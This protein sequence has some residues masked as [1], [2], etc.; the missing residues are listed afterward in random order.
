MDVDLGMFGQGAF[1]MI[2]D[3]FHHGKLVTALLQNEE[4]QDLIAKRLAEL[5]E[6]PLSDESMRTRIDEISNTIRDE[7]PMEAAR[8]GYNTAIWERFVEEIYDHC[9]GRAEYMI[10]N[11]CAQVGFTAAEKQKYFGHLLK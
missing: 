9:D 2:A 11:F 10:N 1:D 3:S 7:I 8:W 4:F 5:L 6:G